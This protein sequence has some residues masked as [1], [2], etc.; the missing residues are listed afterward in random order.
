MRSKNLDSLAKNE[1]KICV[2]QIIMEEQVTSDY[3][4]KGPKALS[5]TNT[6]E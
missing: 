4:Y 2:K 6:C 5:Y 3:L 1:K